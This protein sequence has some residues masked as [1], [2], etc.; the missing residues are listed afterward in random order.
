MD[1]QRP[2]FWFSLV[3]NLFA[4]TES[5]SKVCKWSMKT[6]YCVKN[7]NNVSFR[8]MKAGK[9]SYNFVS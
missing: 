2:L 6:F 7:Q 4:R 8:I 5:S 1:T 9:N 3:F